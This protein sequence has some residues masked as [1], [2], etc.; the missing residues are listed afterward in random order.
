MFQ[1]LRAQAPAG[2][3]GMEKREQMERRTGQAHNL[4]IYRKSGR[5]V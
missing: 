1:Y 5:N 2:P 4:R 3:I